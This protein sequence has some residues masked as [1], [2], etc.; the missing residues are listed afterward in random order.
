MSEKL[1]TRY[2]K[3]PDSA[4]YHRSPNSADFI[5][6]LYFKLRYKI[7]IGHHS[8]ICK[9]VEIKITEGGILKIG[10]HS[11]IAD[12]TFIQLTKPSPHVCIGSHTVIG[13]NCI[14]ASKTNLTIGN[15][16][17]IGAY[18]QII[19]SSHGMIRDDLIINQKAVS[20]P[21]LIRDD[22]WIGAGVKVLHGGGGGLQLARGR[23]WGQ[24]A[25]SQ[26]TFRTMKFGRETPQ[27]LF[28]RENRTRFM[29]RYS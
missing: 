22:V 18:C 27:N 6:T 21:V 12:Y 24:T 7:E 3:Y 15:F 19:D 23:L 14:I 10:H 9:N 28:V 25:S 8:K 2:E 5:R 4:S 20:A 17:L 13:R 29:A 16:V 11:T 26:K 1:V